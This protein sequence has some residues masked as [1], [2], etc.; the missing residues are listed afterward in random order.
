[1]AS[2]PSPG[3]KAGD[4]ETPK[5][6]DAVE[7]AYEASEADKASKAAAKPAPKG[8]SPSKTVPA[9]KKPAA[10]QKKAAPKPEKTETP[11]EPAKAKPEKSEA[12]KVEAKTAP[13]DPAPAPKRSGG[14]KFAWLLVF[15]LLF[16]IGGVAATP[17]LLPQVKPFLP[18]QAKAYFAKL[19]AAG[20]GP[21]VDTSELTARL[22]QLDAGLKDVRQVAAEAKSAAETAPAATAGPDTSAVEALETRLD[23]LV[24]QV[25]Q[26]AS[27]QAAQSDSYARLQE[28]L[29][30]MPADGEGG[31]SPAVV[32]AL[33]TRLDDLASAQTS[34]GSAFDGLK[35][36]VSQLTSDVEAASDGTASASALSQVSDALRARLDSLEERVD[37]V[38]Q[39]ASSAADPQSLATMEDSVS[40]KLSDFETR[41][42]ALENV[43]Q[44]ATAAMVAG[45]ETARLAQAVASGRPYGAELKALTQLKAQA[46]PALPDVSD[47]LDEIAPFA[48]SGIPSGATLASQLEGRARQVLT[49]I[50]TPPDASWWEQLLARVRNL[51]TIRQVGAGADGAAPTDALARAEAAARTG[52]WQ[53]VV[54]EIET[55]PAGAQESL[56]P[57]WTQ[58]QARAKAQQVLADLS[59]RLGVAVI[60]ERLGGDASGAR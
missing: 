7:R 14:G 39:A 23:A 9:S 38:S 51:V 42:G 1:M 52:E 6:Q 37:V 4:K 45:L 5:P 56:G 36:Q 27:A 17:Y 44:Q 19:E 13:T 53:T 30:A 8:A 11:K 43:R 15:L 10:A 12:P 54:S 16:F 55:L 34:A 22:N 21:S 60:D 57:W 58:A 50:D 32:A 46:G 2:E 33:R 47:L 26:V 28:T 59:A 18:D 41:L 49:A 29:S 25:E 20:P 40:G 48:A 35:E 3:N 31:V 24:T